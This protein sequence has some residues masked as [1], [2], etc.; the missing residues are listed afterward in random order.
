MKA[1]ESMR[2]AGACPDAPYAQTNEGPGAACPQ[3]DG[4]PGQSCIAPAPD[5][6]AAAPRKGGTGYLVF[7][8]AF[9]VVFSAAVCIVLAIPVAIA[10][11][12]ICADTPGKP[13]FR[14]ER[15]GKGG[16]RIY[17]F[18][19]RTM[20][21]DAHEHPERY[22]TSVQ[23]ETWRREQ[24]LVNDPRITRV[25]R[26]LRRTS[27]DELPQF[28][29]VLTGD[30]SVIGPR[31]ITLDETYEFGEDRDE[32]LSVRPGITGL[33]QATDRNRATWE[34]GRRQELE[35]RYV[36]NRGYGMDVHIFLMTFRAMF[37]DRTGM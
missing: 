7:K 16:K 30:L 37:L 9:D 24:K 19:L 12:A 13:F 11:A 20:V 3:S 1:T 18:K 14:Q 27:L 8:R 10:C 35:L 22:M 25:G 5:S 32:V 21:A 33:W 17:I 29:N 31:P 2:M 23:L 4:L 28:L 26:F 36:R 34:N 15:I 6:T